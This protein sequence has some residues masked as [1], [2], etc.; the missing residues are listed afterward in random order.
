MKNLLFILAISIVTLF[1]LQTSCSNSNYE[2]WTEER[3]KNFQKICSE[4]DTFNN[5]VILFR[6]FDNSEFDSVLM[7]EYNDTLLVDSFRIF[8]WPAESP[9]DK[10]E[11]KRWTAIERTMNI[12]NRYEFIVSGQ[13]PY[14]LKNM[15]MVIW[16]QD[17]ENSNG[18]GCEM[19]DFT[20]DGVEFKQVGNPTILKRD[21]TTKE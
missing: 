15:K 14:E 19:G 1:F 4:T 20:L 3:I 11:K 12:N 17:T 10:R 8:V 21:T 9:Y 5:I 13:K 18:Y 2:H 6:G 16:S 7:K